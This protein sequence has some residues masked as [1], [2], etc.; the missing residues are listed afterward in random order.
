MS[1]TNKNSL[2]ESTPE[3]RIV[4]LN[5]DKTRKTKTSDTTYQVYF[6][7]SSTP[8]QAWRSAFEKEWM[9]MTKPPL[10]QEATID[11][12]FLVV[13]CPLEEVSACLP[14]LKKT[15]EATNK[16]YQVYAQEQST[17]QE[18]QQNG[19]KKERRAVEVMAESLHF[20]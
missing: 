9:A 4:G 18:R 3:I 19:W 20:E 17:E 16:S 14:I 5:T 2:I 12:K 7:L 1:E 15:I 10:C 8:N 11:N 13:N 6:A